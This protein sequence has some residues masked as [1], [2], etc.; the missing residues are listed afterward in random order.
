MIPEPVRLALMAGLFAGAMAAP[1]HAASFDCAKAAAPDETAICATPSLSDLDVEMA[2]LY[3]VRME[4]PMLMGAR[5][6]AQD[7]QRDFLDKRAACGA[8]AACITQQ[9]GQRIA[10]LKKTI[11]D[12][13]HDYCVKI[14]IC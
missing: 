6:A 5:G 12:G 9:Y 1:G 13:M 8:S 14:G 11:E 4:L 10:A 3:G 2:T 7:E